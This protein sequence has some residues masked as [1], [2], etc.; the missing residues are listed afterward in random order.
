MGAAADLIADRGA[1]SLSADFF[2]SEAFLR[3]EGVTHTLRVVAG[4]ASVAMPVIVREVPG[5]E[6]PDAIS[7]YGY[8]G[9]ALGGDG[10]PP[11]ASDVDWSASGLLSAFL[12]ER[13][14][15]RSSLAG[16]RERSTVLLHDPGRERQVRPRLAEQ[17]RGNERRGWEIVRLDGPEAEAREVDELAALYGQTMTRARAAARYFF[18]PGYFRSILSFDRSWLLLARNAGAVT[19]A[20]AIAALSDDVLHYYLGGTAD[21]ALGESP[22]KNVVA[23]MLDLADELNVPL[24]LGGGVSAGD[25]LESFKRGFSNAEAPFRT[26]E[27]VCAPREYARLA[28][29][30]ETDGFFPAYRAP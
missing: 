7:P 13:I 18:E 20:G 12:R 1:A 26:H 5:S 11:S 21:T 27:I 8:P 23:A 25:G 24:N 6:L 14:G 28:G 16:A 4:G 22:F 29:G 17:I 2:R 30:R 15:P 9:G 19:G 3:A 10:D